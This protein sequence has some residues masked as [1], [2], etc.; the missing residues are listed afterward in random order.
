MSTLAKFG[1][2]QKAQE[3]VSEPGGTGSEPGK[4]PDEARGNAGLNRANHENRV[5]SP[6]HTHARENT[7]ECAYVSPARMDN[8]KYSVQS[9]QSVQAS[10]S[11]D[12]DPV[13]KSADPICPV[14]RPALLPVA[15]SLQARLV[16]VGATVNT[17]GKR[18]SVRAP[19]GIPPELVRE[20]EARGWAI[21]PGGKPNPEAEHDSW[22]AGV[23]IAELDP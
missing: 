12:P 16:A 2:W 1:L 20:V 18:A 11:A 21:I 3:P 23:P 22:L 5:F 14:Q 13:P 17:Y 9:V 15:G 6:S 19:A 7:H 8:D 10:K 4:A